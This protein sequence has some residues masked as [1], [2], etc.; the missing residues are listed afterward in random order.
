[1]KAD[2]PTQCGPFAR[3]ILREVAEDTGVSVDDLRGPCLKRHVAHARQ[4]A[5]FRLY[6]TGRYSTVHVGR[7]L[8]GRDHTTVSKG[9][10]AR[11]ARLA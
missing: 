9:I 5:M 10:R 2:V 4:E 7:I 8:G 3:S 11:E 1:M 6:Q